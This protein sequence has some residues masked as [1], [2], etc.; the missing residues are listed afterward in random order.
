M[1]FCA[2]VYVCDREKG[3][4]RESQL[5]GNIIVFETKAETMCLFLFLRKA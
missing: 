2:C 3:R 1:L 5:S 4:K